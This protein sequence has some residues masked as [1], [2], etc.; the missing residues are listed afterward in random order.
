M[1][2]PLLFAKTPTLLFAIAQ[3][4]TCAIAA[5]VASLCVCPYMMMSSKLHSVSEV[6]VNLAGITAV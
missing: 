4:Y 2:L 6:S 5:V 3:A 1:K